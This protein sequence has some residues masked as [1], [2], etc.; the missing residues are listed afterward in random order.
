MS[1]VFFNDIL[2]VA[3]QYET[4]SNVTAVEWDLRKSESLVMLGP[5]L[6][7]ID[8]EILKPI[9]ERVFAIANRAGI[10]P[11]PP[12]EIAGKMMNIEFVSMLQQAQKATAAAGIERLFQM[13]GGLV[14][15]DPGVMDNIDVDEAIDEYSSLL[16]NSPKIIRSPEQLADIRQQRAQ[17]Q[18]Q[19][20]QA[21]IAQQ[22]SQGA[23]NLSQ[24]NVGGGQNA[25][26]SMLGQG[27]G[28]SGPGAAQ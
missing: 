26:Q 5:V 18:Q 17:A 9:V 27:G 21:Q 22:L 1:Q 2:R 7:R 28:G 23:K 10:L 24:T 19:A 6:E 4:R 25:H 3:S 20:Q 8:D 12:P 13:V 15:V 14:G 16:N 11:P